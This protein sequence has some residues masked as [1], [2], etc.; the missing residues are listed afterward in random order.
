MTESR[1]AKVVRG[2]VRQ[3]DHGMF[4]GY[5]APSEVV[6]LLSKG[7]KL[8]RPQQET[9]FRRNVAGGRSHPIWVYF[10]KVYFK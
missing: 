3:V 8:A 6:F 1:L 4:T 10:S 5:L 9:Y 2:K 7:S